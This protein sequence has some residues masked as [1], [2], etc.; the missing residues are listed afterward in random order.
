MADFCSDCSKEVFGEDFEDHAGLTTDKDTARGIFARVICES[1]GPILVDHHGNCRV[2]I[3][4][5]VDG[6]HS[7]KDN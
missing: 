1:C 7:W 2:H 5:W 4:A 6:V 3:H